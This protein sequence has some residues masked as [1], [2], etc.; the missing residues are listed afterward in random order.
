MLEYSICRL[1]LVGW[2]FST[3]W[4]QR[5]H[6][7]QYGP[8]GQHRPQR[9]FEEVQSGKT[10]HSSSQ[11]SCSEPGQVQGWAAQLGPSLQKVQAAAYHCVGP[12]QKQHAPQ[13][14]EAF[15]TCHHCCPVS[16]SASLHD[17]YWLFLYLF[18]LSIK[19]WFLTV[20]LE[21]AVLHSVLF[22]VQTSLHTNIHCN[23]SLVCFMVSVSE[24]S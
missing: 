14:T 5:Y 16:S 22:F 13:S 24:A 18:Y 20:A 7:P 3:S 11:T 9:S 15:Q 21:T 23:D 4:L 8:P 1:L 17:S 10:N 12:A 19:Y 6:G 2:S